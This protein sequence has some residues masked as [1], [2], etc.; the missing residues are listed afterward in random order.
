MNWS[1]K[2]CRVRVLNLPGFQQVEPT[3]RSHRLL[4]SRQQQ[5][6]N[7]GRLRLKAMT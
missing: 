6:P 4:H 1:P 2:Y 3:T 5:H 7:Q